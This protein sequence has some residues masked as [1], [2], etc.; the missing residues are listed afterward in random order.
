MLEDEPN[1]AM[2]KHPEEPLGA[3]GLLDGSAEL[4]GLTASSPGVGTKK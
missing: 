1:S 3:A 4:N 2:I